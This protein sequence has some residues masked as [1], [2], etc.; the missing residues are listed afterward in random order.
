VIKIS[1]HLRLGGN[2]YWAL[3]LR[4]L[5]ALFLFT[6]CRI[7]FFL[8]NTVYFPEMTFSNFIH[9]LWGGVRF[10]LVAVLYINMLYI[11][12][13]VLPFDFRF[14]GLYQ[15]VTKYLFFVLNGI[16]LAANVCDFVYYKFT[17]RITTADVF[18]QFENEQNKLELIFRFLVDYWYLLVFWVLL[19]IVMVKVYN[20]I[21]IWGPQVKNRWLYYGI[22]TLVIPLIAY[23]MVAGIRGGFRH[24]T[25]PIT[26]SN[27]GEYV[28]DPKEISIVLNTPFAIIRTAK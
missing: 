17:L 19:I 8:F 6:V 24:S 26:L 9:L 18:Q 7:G 3:F 25:R 13:M 10:D 21:R 12:L 14:N 23:L 2:I 16:G 4:L 15:K 5:L 11:L 20:M 1:D 28:N 27:A 22:G